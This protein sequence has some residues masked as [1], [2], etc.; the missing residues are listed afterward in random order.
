MTLKLNFNE[1]YR[2][3]FAGGFA[4]IVNILSR[5]IFSNFFSYRISIIFAFFLGLTTAY[6]LMR[7]YVFNFKKN[8]IVKQTIRFA[9]INFFALFQ[10]FVITISCKYI[11][12]IFFWNLDH[13]M[14]L[15]NLPF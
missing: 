4:A 5:I 1:I 9:L 14:I 6:F 10:T 2:F 11:L 3:L 13:H 7:N 8:H 12:N 15:P